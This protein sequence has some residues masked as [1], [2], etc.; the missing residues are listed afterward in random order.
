M[1]SNTIFRALEELEG[2]NSTFFKQYTV[3]DLKEYLSYLGIPTY[4]NGKVYTKEKLVDLA[5]NAYK[6]KLLPSLDKENRDELIAK[7]HHQDNI[8]L[9]LITNL[10]TGWTKNLTHAPYMLYPD[11]YNYLINKPG[12]DLNGLKAYKSLTAYKLMTDGHVEDLQINP[13][14]RFVFI[15][16]KVKLTQRSKTWNGKAVYEPWAIVREN[17]VV[18][19][20]HMSVLAAMMEPAGMSLLVFLNLKEH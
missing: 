2:A 16:W 5:V 13:Q 18:L 11:I 19:A 10:K 17:G 20:A 8:H 3:P 7:K 1:S 14:G 4:H 12:Y 9:P 6:L 15:K